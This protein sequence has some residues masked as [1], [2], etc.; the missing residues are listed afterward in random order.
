MAR[1]NL[2]SREREI[3]GAPRPDRPHRDRVV[4]SGLEM[5]PV[6]S[7]LQVATILGVSLT[8]LWRMVNRGQFPRG[9]RISPGRVGWRASTLRDWLAVRSSGA[10]YHER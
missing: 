2:V 6:L 1:P 5:D 10:A 7:R 9:I 8:T 4:V 3:H